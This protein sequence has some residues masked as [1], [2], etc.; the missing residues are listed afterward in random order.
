MSDPTA[1]RLVQILQKMD[2]KHASD[3]F[4]AV[5]KPVSMRIYGK[6][7][8]YSEEPIT[9]EQFDTF[10]TTCLP[11]GVMERIKVER[12]LDIGF[13]LS[14]SER[15]RLNLMHQKGSIAGVARRVPLGEMSFADLEL[16]VVFKSLACSPRGLILVTGATG[17]GKSSSVASIVHYINTRFA[18]HIVT[19][20]DP[21]EFIHRDRK[22]VITQREV[23]NDTQDFAGSLRQV[24]RQS[25]D[26]IVIGELR[27][28]ESIQTAI[29][30]A[31]TGHLVIT[32][33]H[34]VDVTQTLERIINYYP[35]HLRDQIAMDLSMALAGVVSQRLIPLMSGEGLI[36]VCEV[37]LATPLVRRHISQRNFELIEEVIKTSAADGMITFNRSLAERYHAGKISK[38]AGAAAASNRDEF[39]LIVEGMETGIDTLRTTGETDTTHDLKVDMKRLLK[40]AIKHDASDLIITVGSAPTLRIDGSLRELNMENLT[41]PESRR[42]LFSLLNPSQRSKFEAEKEI[43]FAL[44]VSNLVGGEKYEEL[45]G[46]RFRINGFYQKGSVAIA[47]RVIASKIPTPQ[48]LG[49]P[50]AVLKLAEKHHGL[51]LITGP[52]GHGKSTT[53]AC[54]IDEINRN[55]SC[56]IITVEDPI[57]FVHAKRKAIIEQREVYADTKSFAAALKYVLRQDPDVILIG[58]MR[59]Q[60]TISAALTAAE[61]GH[62]VLA[63][64]HTNDAVQTMDRIID[65][66]PPYQQGQIRAQLAAALLGVV[67]QRLIPRVDKKG[68]IAAFEILVGTTAVQ[69]LIRDNRHHQIPA[70]IETS[71]KDGMITM[72]K[73][74]KNLYSKNLIDRQSYVNLSK[75]PVDHA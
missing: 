45:K 58:E 75:N 28:Y 60:E 46:H 66:F 73:A 65:T 22:S 14:E 1:S 44:S 57:E 38:E 12:D 49:I 70:T 11:A 37:L 59:D 15:Y 25:P 9:Q 33:M 72:D 55:R 67:S 71:A 8:T 27:D 61:T 40:A 47:V 21:I 19:I 54:M 31:M 29:S 52:T 69:A 36:P 35:D 10:V 7:E 3:V 43:D 56:H 24:V 20:E 48:E 42:L 6:L 39:L 53:L 68:R 17:S 16:P 62:L 30:A 63:T 26:V 34:T 64:L 13:S 32:T 74:L 23:G 5:G 50:T 51:I 18:K 2:E 4:F 41:P